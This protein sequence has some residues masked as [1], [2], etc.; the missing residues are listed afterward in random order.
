MPMNPAPTIER[1]AGRVGRGAHG[2]GVVE[3]AV[4]EDAV[5]VARRESRAARGAD[6]VASTSRS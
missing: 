3:G 4:G 6:P 2:R 5:E 1:P